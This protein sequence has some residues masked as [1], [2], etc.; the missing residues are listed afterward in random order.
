MGIFKKFWDSLNG[1]KTVIA[2]LYWGFVMP[3]LMLYYPTGTPIQVNRVVTLIGF[4]LTA[5]GL[6]HKF[7]K[8]NI[9]DKEAE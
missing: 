3:G 9:A 2:S 7:Y 5:V 8:S 4:F 1:K 6:G